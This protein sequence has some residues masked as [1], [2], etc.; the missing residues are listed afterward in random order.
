M[1]LL[2]KLCQVAV[3]VSL[4][5]VWLA[6]SGKPTPFRGGDAKSLR[7]EFTGYGL[8]GWSV[9]VVGSAKVS[10][11]LCLL[12]GIYFEKL[13][14]PAALAFIFLM[15]AAVWRHLKNRRD[16]LIKAGPAYLILSACVFLLFD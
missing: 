10:L 12:A 9:W 11:S 7:D 2:P 3:A 14:K 13:V 16:P 5:M 1:D 15:L 4:L 6:R 8:P